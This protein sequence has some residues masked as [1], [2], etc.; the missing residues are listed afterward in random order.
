MSDSTRKYQPATTVTHAG[1]AD[2]TVQGPVNPGVIRASTQLF[3]DT[4]AL[5]AAAGSRKS[6]GRYGTE[7]HAALEQVLCELEG[8]ESCLLTPSGLSAVTTTLLGLLQ[9]GDHLL[10][11]DSVYDP[12]RNCC[13]NL[14]K[15]LGIVTTYY[16]PTMGADIESLILPTTKVI[17]VESPGSH[18]FEVQDIPAIAEVAHERGVLV[19]SDS[20]WATPIGWHATELGVDVSLHAATKYIGGHSDVMLGAILGS[21]E[22]FKQIR[23]VH[24]LL[25]IAVS[26]DEASL[27]LRGLRTLTTRMAAHA[28]AGLVVARWLKNQPEVA[29]V[30]YPPLPGSPGHDLWKR[31][32]NPQF[33][34]S[35]MGVVFKPGVS[36]E[37]VEALVDSV[38]LFGIG[39]SWG[40]Y[41]SLILASRPARTRTVTAADWSSAMARIHVGLESVDDL[42]ADLEVGFQALRQHD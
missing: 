11:P 36:H 41:E 9:P 4:R 34:A 28:Q 29:E 13:E 39:Y 35:L 24:T 8:M 26:A 7:T 42:M 37:A 32:F 25:G 31:D 10:M 12:T 18:T 23:R 6:Y 22:T 17:F 2:K 20:T 3:P 40:G 15:P 16:R 19:V 33:A 21:G 5:H 14:L 30:L 38:R 1:R 27:A